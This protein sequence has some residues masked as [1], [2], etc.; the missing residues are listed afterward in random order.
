MVVVH[1]L[2]QY[3]SL[4]TWLALK[5]CNVP[6]LIYPHGMI[7]PWFNRTYPVKHLKKILY[8]RLFEN[9]VL[10]DAKSVLFTSEEEKNLARDSFRPYNISE[11]VVS[12]GISA[13]KVNKSHAIRIFLESFPHLSDRKI[14]LFVGRIHPKKGLDI[15]IKAFSRVVS[16]D[17]S[18][19]LVIAGPDQVGFK[20]HLLNLANF[21]GVA[22][23]IT[24]S[25]ML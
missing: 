1:G 14:I 15:L 3:H 2:W 21:L 8:W 10:R 9:K 17:P 16:A 23:C 11:S 22:D 5:D 25:G 13:P 4:A 19:H 12:Y 24:W 20:I 7:D 6:Y 18:L